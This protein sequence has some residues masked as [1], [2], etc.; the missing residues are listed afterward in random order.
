MPAMHSNMYSGMSERQGPYTYEDAMYRRR[1]LESQA[2][3]F[4]PVLHR[5]TSAN[6]VTSPTSSKLSPL[7]T[8]SGHFESISPDR[9][10]IHNPHHHVS[11][12][13]PNGHAPAPRI[14][15]PQLTRAHSSPHSLQYNIPPNIHMQQPPQHHPH[16]YSPQHHR[17]SIQQ[18][19]NSNPHK[20]MQPQHYSQHGSSPHIEVINNGGVSTPM[21]LCSLS[22]RDSTPST[23][24][25]TPP[26]S[27]PSPLQRPSFKRSV[28]HSNVYNYYDNSRPHVNNMTLSAPPTTFMETDDGDIIPSSNHLGMDE[29]RRVSPFSPP[30][31]TISPSNHQ[32]QHHHHQQQQQHQHHCETCNNIQQQNMMQQVKPAFT[33]PPLRKASST[34]TVFSHGRINKQSSKVGHLSPTSIQHRNTIDPNVSYYTP[35]HTSPLSPSNFVSSPT[36]GDRLPSISQLLGNDFVHQTRSGLH[37]N[38]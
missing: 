31:M 23:P 29:L 19:V 6:L 4:R 21:S 24:H 38:K 26:G 9:N 13:S 34:N 32:Q 20:Q 3:Q 1:E 18:F 15:R 36:S 25:G 35:I 27:H 37:V 10:H 16:Q 28:S 2:T 22:P 7:H 8:N 5:S 14:I 30:V 33:P 17:S 11:P 12:V